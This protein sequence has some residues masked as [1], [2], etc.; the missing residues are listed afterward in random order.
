MY[1][2]VLKCLRSG[3][4]SVMR[5]KPVWNSTIF[6]GEKKKKKG[7]GVLQ[8]NQFFCNP[9]IA[10]CCHEIQEMLL[11]EMNRLCDFLQWFSFGSNAMPVAKVAAWHLS[12]VALS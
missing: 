4:T 1:G 5:N 3:Q 2:I 11:G 9:R 12:D 8:K 10:D 6:F 7:R